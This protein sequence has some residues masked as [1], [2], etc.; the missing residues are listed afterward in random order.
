M[1]GRYTEALSRAV[2]RYLPII[3]FASS[4]YG[5]SRICGVI[6][7][8]VAAVPYLLIGLA[9]LT[10]SIPL[11]ARLASILLYIEVILLVGVK[12]GWFFNNK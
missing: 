1:G 4:L 2:T 6:V 3:A 5:A 9:S 7:V 12:Y 8:S 11:R 10:H